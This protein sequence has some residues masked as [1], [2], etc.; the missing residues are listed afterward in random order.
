LLI[1]PLIG[2]L[3]RAIENS[4]KKQTIEIGS[5]YFANLIL[6]SNAEPFR[7]SS[8]NNGLRLD[9]CFY[10][11]DNNESLASG[12]I[13][14]IIST[15]SKSENTASIY[16][17]D[18]TMESD[19]I[20]NIIIHKGNI[21]Y[22]LC[23]VSQA[24]ASTIES[25]AFAYL[26]NGNFALVSIGNLYKCHQEG[27]LPEHLYSSLIRG[28]VYYPD[29]HEQKYILNRTQPRITSAKESNEYHENAR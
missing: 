1:A 19:K 9:Q 23:N 26:I 2:S 27:L 21:F 10:L 29:K 24:I 5:K 8:P 4:I 20:L 3:Y 13:E 25:A 15:F 14:K 28:N 11:Y 17:E 18:H 7:E 12:N 22:C 6:I 16:V